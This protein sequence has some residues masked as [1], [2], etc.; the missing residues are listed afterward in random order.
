MDEESFKKTCIK[1]KEKKG[2]TRQPFYCT[3]VR[4][5]M[6][7]QNAGRCWGSI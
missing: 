3:W 5:F 2:G 1:E 7:K 4:D 6:L